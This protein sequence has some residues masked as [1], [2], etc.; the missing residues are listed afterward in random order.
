MKATKAQRDCRQPEAGSLQP[1]A[2]VVGLPAAS[3]LQSTACFSTDRL[4]T[5]RAAGGVAR[6]YYPFG[7]EIGTPSANNTYKFASTYRDSATGLDYAI[8][9][10]YASGTARFLTPD[11]YQASGGPADPQ[12][13]NR[14]AYTRNDPVNLVDAMGL[15]YGP[16]PETMTPGTRE[17]DEIEAPGGEGPPAPTGSTK[18]GITNALNGIQTI[19]LGG[20]RNNARC[21]SLF[22]ALGAQVGVSADTLM[23]QVVS[24]ASDILQHSYVYEGPSSNTPLD[25]DKFPDAASPGVSTVGQWFAQNNNRQALSQFNGSA[26]LIRQDDWTGITGQFVSGVSSQTV[27][28]YGLGAL[29]HEILHKQA[30]GGGFTHDQMQAALDAIGAPSP[31][32]GRAAQADRTGQV[33]F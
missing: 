19:S 20:F 10:Y 13:W 9:R 4:G 22:A 5:V 21:Q 27:N 25:P 24:V 14:Y 32:L 6:N 31:T 8:N 33:C 23:N 7:E 26:I 2:S 17:G 16:P 30:V 12:S 28:Q 15:F 11:P 1:G 18:P 29:L 3:S